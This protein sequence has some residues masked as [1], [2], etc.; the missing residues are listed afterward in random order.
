M[1]TVGGNSYHLLIGLLCVRFQTIATNF[2]LSLSLQ[3]NLMGPHML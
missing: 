2:V 1:G 3:A